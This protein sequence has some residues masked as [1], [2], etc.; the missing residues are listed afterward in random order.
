MTKLKIKRA[1]YKILFG[2]FLSSQTLVTVFS[3]KRIFS[4]MSLRYKNAINPHKS[5]AES[6]HSGS[7]CKIKSNTETPDCPKTNRFCGLPN[8]VNIEPLMAAM[9]SITIT[10]RIYFSFSPALN[11]KI[12]SGTKIIRETSFSLQHRRLK[13]AFQTGL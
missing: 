9:F 5:T 13:T 8:G 6:T 10:G 11:N 12:V 3:S 7:M 4:F 1:I 2:L